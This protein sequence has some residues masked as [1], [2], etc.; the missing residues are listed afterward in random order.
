MQ[1]S[2]LLEANTSLPGSDA[3]AGMKRKRV[4]AEEG[5][6]GLSGAVAAV[7]SSHQGETD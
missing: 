2:N 4:E 7:G 6:E 3:I 5:D 1:N